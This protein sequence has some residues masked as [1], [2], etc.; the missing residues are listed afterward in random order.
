MKISRLPGLALTVVIFMALSA[1]MTAA[2]A[3]QTAEVVLRFSNVTN[4]PSVDAAKVLIDVAAKE[5]NGRLEIRHFPNNMLGD[6]RA[7][8]ESA[9]MGDIALVQTQPSVL[10]SLIPDLHIWDIPFLFNKI[11]DAWECLDSPLGQAI[12]SE[13]EREGLKYL[14]AVENG[15]RHYTNNTVPVRVPEDIKG[16]KLRIMQT[17]LQLAMWKRLGAVPVP[18][19]F[20]EV[21]SALQQ[22]IVEAQENPLSIIDAN[23]IYEIQ[24]YISLTA[25]V[26]SPHILYI[27]KEIYD[28]LEPDLKAALDKAVAAYQ[29]AQRRRAA[30]LNALSI[31]K[32]KQAGCEIVELTDEEHQKWKQAVTDS[33][34]YK[35]VRAKLE[36]PEYLDMILKHEY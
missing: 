18:M 3:S 2:R 4:Q 7:V 32:F 9:I 21:I 35:L 24:H 14:A 5:S 34:I 8:T 17:D 6:D 29:T 19:I 15:F 31:D 11:E 26:F 23:K 20:T 16:Q 28:S 10:S 1:C 30:E 13:V 36:H 27:N 22:G 12:N 33:G 25:H